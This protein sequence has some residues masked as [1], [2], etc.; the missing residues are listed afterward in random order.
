MARGRSGG[1]LSPLW[2]P[3]QGLGWPT[4]VTGPVTPIPPVIRG[5]QLG[6]KSNHCLHRSSSSLPPPLLSARSAAPAGGRMRKSCATASLLP[7]LAVD[8]AGSMG[9]PVSVVVTCHAGAHIA[10]SS[11]QCSSV[12]FFLH[13]NYTPPSFSPLH[14]LYQV[15]ITS[16]SPVPLASTSCLSDKRP[17][18]SRS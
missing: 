10:A 6:L 8:C 3:A 17:A 12:L 7:I 16:F 15:D 13:R 14:S 18:I 5:S 9:Q 2:V 1:L 4:E 11:Y